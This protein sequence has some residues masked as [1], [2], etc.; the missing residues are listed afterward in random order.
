MLECPHQKEVARLKDLVVEQVAEMQGMK[1]YIKKILRENDKLK[2]L[3]P[4]EALADLDGAGLAKKM[5]E[6]L[7]KMGVPDDI[8]RQIIESAKE[9]GIEPENI[10]VEDL[11]GLFTVQKPDK[12]NVC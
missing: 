8:A 7:Q 2:A 12:D 4:Q 3:V 5:G 10:H 1:R 11:S 6:R 9:L